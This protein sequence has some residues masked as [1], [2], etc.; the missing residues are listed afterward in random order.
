MHFA[1]DSGPD[2]AGEISREQAADY[3]SAFHD[4]R[5]TDQTLMDSASVA[6]DADMP[7]VSS[8][9]NNRTF[10]IGPRNIYNYGN[11]NLNIIESANNAVHARTNSDCSD[12]EVIVG[13][14]EPR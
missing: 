5:A 13:S 6:N 14:K 2:A 7:S 10:C 11:I 4:Q 8:E 1:S 3:P 9:L 12:Y